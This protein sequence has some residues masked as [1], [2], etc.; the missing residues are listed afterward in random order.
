MIGTPPLRPPKLN[1]LL[2]EDRWVSHGAIVLLRDTMK[3]T[4]PFEGTCK[5]KGRGNKKGDD[6]WSKGDVQQKGH[7]EL[8]KSYKSQQENASNVSGGISEIYK[9]EA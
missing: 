7:Q 1:K 8:P 4:V 9:A 5:P 6:H 3:A 2:A